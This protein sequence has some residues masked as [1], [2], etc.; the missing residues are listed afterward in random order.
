PR[1]VSFAQAPV[2]EWRESRLVLNA[3]VV[4]STFPRCG[5]IFNTPGPGGDAE[6]GLP[7]ARAC[8][9]S[10]PPPPAHR[11][12]PGISSTTPHPPPPLLNR[13]RPRRSHRSP[14]LRN[15][16]WWRPVWARG[17][18]EDFTV[19]SPQTEKFLTRRNSRLL[20]ELSP[21]VAE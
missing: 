6:G 7:G 9:P 13:T 15:Q 1:S 19:S 10:P 12:P 5:E 18:G 2:L 21:G 17:T 14:H 16:P 11:P 3:A 20:I 4:V 8:H